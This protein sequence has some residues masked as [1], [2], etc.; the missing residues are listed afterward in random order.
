[1]PWYKNTLF[2]ITSDHTNLS[3]H[4]YYQTDLG[5]FCSPIIFFDPSG[6]FKPGMRDAI[7]Q[8]IDIMPTV[9]SYLGYDKKYVGFGIDLLTTPAKDT[10][11]VNYNNGFYQYVKGD[12]LLQWDGQQTKA[13]Y[14]FRT[15]LLL[16]NN[17]ADKELAVRKAME[18]EVKAI[19]QSYMERMTKN[20]LVVGNQSQQ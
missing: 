10:W 16:E 8:Q 1:M 17:V 7:A 19:I 12:Y 15:D 5:G 6:E 18:R 14:R 9:L 11:A 20:E 3:D 4:A 13:L 2:V